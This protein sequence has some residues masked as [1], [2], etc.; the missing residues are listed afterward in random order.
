MMKIKITG[1]SLFVF[2]QIFPLSGQ[3]QGIY[4]SKKEYI[5]TR[6]IPFSEARDKLPSPIYDEDTAYVSCYWKAWEIAFKNFYEPSRGS[7]FVSQFADA[8]FNE[9]AFAYD[10]SFLTMFLN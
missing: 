1:I 7:G 9:N 8:A 6:M 5:P 2:L 4:F 10:A 3:N